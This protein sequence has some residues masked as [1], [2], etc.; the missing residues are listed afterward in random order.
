MIGCR[1]STIS[2]IYDAIWCRNI[3]SVYVC[4]QCN[5]IWTAQNMLLLPSSVGIPTLSSLSR[6]R[7]TRLKSPELL[8]FSFITVELKY[9][10]F[11]WYSIWVGYFI[12]S[13][14]LTLYSPEY[15][16]ESLE[17]IPYMNDGSTSWNSRWIGT[18]KNKRVKKLQLLKKFFFLNIFKKILFIKKKR[19]KRKKKTTHKYTYILY[20][21]R[22]IACHSVYVLISSVGQVVILELSFVAYS[23]SW[24]LSKTT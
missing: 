13:G 3:S 5:C 16:T 15:S 23:N 9:F 21:S 17:S 2:T 11:S 18:A 22:I 10:C 1:K 7:L 19:R 4:G 14:T 20:N 6:K 8:N 12:F 24:L